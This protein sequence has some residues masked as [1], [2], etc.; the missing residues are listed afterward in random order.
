MSEPRDQ[1]R[2][3]LDLAMLALKSRPSMTGAAVVHLELALE[4]LGRCA[5]LDDNDALPCCVC[6][7]VVVPIRGS[8]DVEDGS[9]RTLVWP[10]CFECDQ[11]RCRTCGVLDPEYPHRDDFRVCAKCDEARREEVA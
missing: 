9:Y 3:Q 2:H 8:R 6:G 4:V 1:L 5:I 7:G 10:S 11:V